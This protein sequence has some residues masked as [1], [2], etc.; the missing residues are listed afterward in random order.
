MTLEEKKTV[1]SRRKIGRKWRRNK[2]AEDNLK[3]EDEA[4]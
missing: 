2:R 1:W 3:K 4:F